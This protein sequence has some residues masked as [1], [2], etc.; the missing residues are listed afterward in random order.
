MVDHPDAHEKHKRRAFDGVVQLYEA[1]HVAEPDRGHDLKAAAWRDR[2]G[3]WVQASVGE[4]A[5]GS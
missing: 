4:R 2:L 3:A 1:W 5:G